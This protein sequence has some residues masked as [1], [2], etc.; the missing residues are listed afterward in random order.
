MSFLNHTEMDSS[1]GQLPIFNFEVRGRIL[2]SVINLFRE[3]SMVSF[4]W[5]TLYH[6]RIDDNMNCNFIIEDSTLELFY[7]T[8]Q[9]KIL[10]VSKAA[11]QQESM[12]PMGGNNKAPQHIHHMRKVLLTYSFLI[13][14][15]LLLSQNYSVDHFTL[16]HFMV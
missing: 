8:E 13:I 16:Y 5:K 1:T 2:T 3:S 15:R 12:R 4:G 9:E 7:E 14:Y 6:G 11:S 10:Y